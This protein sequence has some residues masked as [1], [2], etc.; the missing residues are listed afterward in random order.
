MVGP[1][2][3]DF[4]CQCPAPFKLVSGI[5]DNIPNGC[6]VAVRLPD[7]SIECHLCDIAGHYIL[8]TTVY[9][10]CDC[11]SGYYMD[12]NG[13]CQDICGDGKLLLTDCDDGNLIFGDGC[14]NTCTF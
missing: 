2:N 1:P 14:S 9:N 8:S 5:C 4:C 13:V 3:T 10:Q 12:G 7:D 6:G 11:M